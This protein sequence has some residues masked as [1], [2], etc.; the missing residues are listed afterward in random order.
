MEDI[1]VVKVE[2]ADYNVEKSRGD[3]TRRNYWLNRLQ[4]V[5][6]R[7]FKAIIIS[8]NRTISG[9]LSDK[10]IE[11]TATELCRVFETRIGAVKNYPDQLETLALEI[12]K[13]TEPKLPTQVERFEDR[14]DK[15]ET[16]FEF[17]NR[18][19]KKYADQGI[20]YQ[21]ELR[22]RD[23]ILYERLHGYFKSVKK[24]LAEETKMLP[25]KAFTERKVESVDMGSVRAKQAMWQRTYR[26][27]KSS[28]D[29]ER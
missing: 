24:N 2:N 17:F 25:K 15:L 4:A 22:R 28:R 13:M 9:N 7:I 27:N 19:W 16:S 6:F 11:Q 10:D 26:K 5:V 23:R 29:M 21:F 8:I 3:N 18:V 20:L 12:E 14:M 1:D